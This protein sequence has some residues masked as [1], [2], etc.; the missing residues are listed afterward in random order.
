MDINTFLEEV[1]QNAKKTKKITNMQLKCYKWWQDFHSCMVVK[2]LCQDITFSLPCDTL[3]VIL[4]QFINHKK[5][6]SDREM[7]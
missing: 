3:S 2:Q 6:E 7:T 4:T 5:C 1:L